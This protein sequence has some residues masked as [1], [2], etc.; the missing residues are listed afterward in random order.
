MRGYGNAG[1][2]DSGFAPLAAATLKRLRF[3]VAGPRPPGT[4]AEALEGSNAGIPI[5]IACGNYDRVQA[6][7]DGRVKVDG[8]TVNFL[9]LYPEEIFHRVFKFQEFE[10]A[11]ISGSSFI[12][13]V[14]AGM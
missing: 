14:S 7:K 4:A 13:M 10:V 3:G 2:M 8:C 11:E 9:P 5:T 1:G 6:I 12:R